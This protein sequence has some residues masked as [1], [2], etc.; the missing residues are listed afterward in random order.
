[1]VP[2]VIGDIRI[3]MPI[4]CRTT[5]VK[6]DEGCVRICAHVIA[7]GKPEEFTP[8]PG[9]NHPSLRSLHPRSEAQFLNRFVVMV[10]PH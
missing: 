3:A 1:M 5:I 8:I 9:S 10:F 4:M 2:L 7:Y 6:S